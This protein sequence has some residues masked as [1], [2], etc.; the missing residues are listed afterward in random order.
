MNSF[1]CGALDGTISGVRRYWLLSV[2][3]IV[4]ISL[5]PTI[6]YCEESPS[7]IGE[8]QFTMIKGR[9]VP[10]CE[11][12]L[13]LL[14][15]TLFERTP[16]CG[17]P[18]TGPAPFAPL[19]RRDLGVNEMLPLF[20]Y[21]WEFMRFNDQHHV[22]KFFYSNV[23]PSKSY[24]STDA[25]TREAI[26]QAVGR[27]WT[28]VWTYSKPIDIAN[29]GNAM[30]LLIWQG[31]GA[32]GSGAACGGDY[33]SGAW[34]DTYT[35]QRVFVLTA[36]GKEIDESQTRAIFGI[37][38]KRSSRESAAAQPPAHIPGMPPGAKPFIALSDSIGIFGY[39]NRYYI[40][41]ENKPKAR[42][43]SPPAVEVLLR[44]TGHTKKVCAFRPQSVPIPE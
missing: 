1:R 31:Y 24:W 41:T 35:Q 34:D 13:E 8:N 21:V 32:A 9:G 12:Y 36:D 20:N 22:E 16:F 11:A 15:K 27:G 19:E 17:R 14:N 29:D 10:V 5:S 28:H 38:A 30:P 18:D 37:A 33:A 44:D 2:V 7:K 6:S 39:D 3:T 43:E 4:A 42:G 23:D 25:T 26:G 40:Q